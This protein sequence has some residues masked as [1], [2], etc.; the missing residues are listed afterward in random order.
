MIRLRHWHPLTFALVP[1]LYFAAKNLNV[2]SGADV[3]IAAGATLA[4]TAALVVLGAL[5]TRDADKS[6][7]I[8]SVFIIT[9]FTAG[10][11]YEPLY[12][13]GVG[14]VG[15]IV[16]LQW[17]IALAITGA[18][19]VL[20]WRSAAAREKAGTVLAGMGVVLLVLVGARLVQP[21]QLRALIQSPDGPPPSHAGTVAAESAERPDIYYIIPDSYP[22][23]DAL[24]RYH[25]FDN[26]EFVDWLGARGFYVAERSWAN[27]PKTY[28]ALSSS[29]GMRYVNDITDRIRDT[30]KAHNSAR[31]RRPLYALIQAPEV[32][33][34]LQARGYRYATVLSNW[35][36]SNASK[37]ADVKYAISPL[38]QNEFFGL[39]FNRSLLS[40]FLPTLAD[41]HRFTIEKAKTLPALEGPTFSFV[42]LLLPHPPFVFDESGNVVTDHPLHGKLGREDYWLMRDAYIAQLRYTNRVLRDVVETILAQSKVPPII[43]IQ[44]DHGSAV[45]QFDGT[46]E[47]D[48]PQPEE[49]MAILNA[50]LVPDAVRAKL[51]PTISPVNSFRAIL[52]AQFGEDLPLLPDQSWFGTSADPYVLTDVTARLAAAP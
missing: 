20:V 6:S 30:R 37:S 4:V 46:R 50:Y 33:R 25:G 2:V 12:Q 11:T 49:R 39:L 22:R 1:I 3:A 36:G 21:D 9:F 28:L 35:G 18:A 26:R 23:L 45:T 41:L 16:T 42:H 10:D 51:Y 14:S 48:A 44:G 15:A 17:V 8:L 38:F 24:A 7:A 43:V 34:R 27:Y 31:D 47:L 5:L 52:S 32:A 29:L 40:A 19:G 13:A